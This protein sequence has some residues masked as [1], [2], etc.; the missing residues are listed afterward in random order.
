MAVAVAVRAAVAVAIWRL[1][2]R[3]VAYKPAGIG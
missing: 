1:Q 3:R 2:I